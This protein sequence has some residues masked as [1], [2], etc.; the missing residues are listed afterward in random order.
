[1]S[2]RLITYDWRLAF[3]SRIIQVC[4]VI[5]LPPSSAL[6]SPGTER[7]ADRV[8]L[9]GDVRGLLPRP[10][11]FPL[12]GGSLRGRPHQDRPTVSINK[13][14]VQVY[15]DS[16]TSHICSHPSGHPFM[17]TFC[18]PTLHVRGGSRNSL[19]G[20]GVLGQ[21]SSRGGGLGSRSVEFSYT[22]K[23]KQKEKPSEGGGGG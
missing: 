11:V 17:P 4:P 1:M 16:V 10:D 20:G 3:H 19:R 14:V 13:D 7:P 22:D 12:G 9:R 15:T 8:Q 21:N 2:K 18:T 6:Y 5:C 23:P